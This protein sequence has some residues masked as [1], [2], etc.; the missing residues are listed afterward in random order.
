[1]VRS[2][3]GY[4]NDELVARIRRIVYLQAQGL[5]LS[6]I[7]RLLAGRGP[8]F[9]QLAGLISA[10]TGPFQTEY[11]EVLSRTELTGEACRVATG[12]VW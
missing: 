5:K 9:E 6:A 2:R 4:Y 3:I 8:S 1:V 10:I 12:C 11:P 7:E